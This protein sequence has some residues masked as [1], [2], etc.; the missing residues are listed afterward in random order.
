[1]LWHILQKELQLHIK[2]L[3]FLISFILIVSLMIISG[4][5]FIRNYSQK[6]SDYRW[7]VSKNDQ[8]LREASGNLRKLA[9]R[10]QF[11]M[12]SPN[13]LELCAEGGENALPNAFTLNAFLITDEPLR[14]TRANFMLPRFRY[15]DWAFIFSVVLSFVVFILTYDAISG[16]KEQG[17]L[18]LLLS[19]SIPRATVLMAKYLSVLILILT[20]FLVGLLLNLL[21][22]SSSSLIAFSRLE[23]LKILTFA[24]ISLVYLSLFILIGMFVSCSTKSPVA[25]VII[26]LFI[27]VIFVVIIP[28]SVGMLAGKLHPIPSKKEYMEKSWGAVSQLWQTAPREATGYHGTPFHKDYPL[29]HKLM[30]DIEAARNRLYDQFAKQMIRQVRFARNLTRISPTAVYQNLCEAIAGVGLPRFE[31]FYAQVVRYRERLRDFIVSEDKKDP[32]SAHFVNHEGFGTSEKPVDFDAIPK[33][34]ER[35]I[36]LSDSL[37]ALWDVVLLILFN[38]AFFVLAFVAFLRYDV[39]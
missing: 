17:T 8:T 1:M 18:G 30:C 29:R 21:I 27:W 22:V 34:Q 20:P 37:H 26:L 11:L 6:V 14:E 25:S 33:F 15:L 12:K 13:K 28:N 16:E 32:E 38:L 4:F 39:R 35:P 10:V 2:S 36:P 7:A 9:E 5:V 23:W 19:N 3:R 31:S 24:G